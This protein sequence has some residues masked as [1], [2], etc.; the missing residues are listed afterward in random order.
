MDSSSTNANLDLHICPTCAS[1]CEQSAQTHVYKRES[2]VSQMC[3]PAHSS[4]HGWGCCS[5][6]CG[7]AAGRRSVTTRWGCWW[8]QDPPL[9]SSGWTAASTAPSWKGKDDSRKAWGRKFRNEERGKEVLVLAR[10]WPQND[11][12]QEKH[13]PTFKSAPSAVKLPNLTLAHHFLHPIYKHEQQISCNE[14]CCVLMFSAK[15]WKAAAQR[16]RYKTDR[17]QITLSNKPQSCASSRISSF[18]WLRSAI[19]QETKRL[20]RNYMTW[21]KWPSRAFV[22]SLCIIE[23]KIWT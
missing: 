13:F 2:G 4:V 22:I 23:F 9:W 18:F 12:S 1:F 19:K 11:N 16:V 7:A 14:Q 3:W 5:C 17:Y 6:P 20:P 10:L 8:T 15:L 21:F